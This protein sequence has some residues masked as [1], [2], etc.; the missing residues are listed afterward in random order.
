[1]RDGFRTGQ[2]QIK[3]SGILISGCPPGLSFSMTRITIT[4]MRRR[5]TARAFASP[6]TNWRRM[7]ANNLLI[8]TK[9]LCFN[10]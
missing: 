10:N 9:D 3:Q 8:Y 4:R 6:V 2:I 5:G 7:Q 1:M